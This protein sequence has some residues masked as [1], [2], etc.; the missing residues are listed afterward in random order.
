LEQVLPV[1]YLGSGQV[2]SALWPLVTALRR[3]RPAT[4][5]SASFHANCIAVVAKMLARSR[6]RVVIS[7]H[8]ALQ[9]GLATLPRLTRLIQSLCI[10]MLYPR[11]D[12]WVAVSRAVR[13]SMAT[14]AAIAPEKITVIY[15]PV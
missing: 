13:T 11:A 14:T 4:L 5:L 3:R 15:N 9:T 6:A 8:T 1:H 12:A 7:E 10:R 2:R